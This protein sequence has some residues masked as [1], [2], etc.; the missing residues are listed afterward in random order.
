MRSVSRLF[1]VVAGLLLLLLLAGISGWLPRH[2]WAPIVLNRVLPGIE[3]TELRGLTVS[4][5]T[6]SLSAEIEHLHLL[7]DS[8]LGVTIEGARLTDLPALLRRALSGKPRT[9]VTSQLHI[10]SVSLQSL[11]TAETCAPSPTSSS[12]P[13]AR[14]PEHP[15]PTVTNGPQPSQILISDTLH[16]LRN[17]PISKVTVDAFNWPQRIDGHLSLTALNAPGHQISAQI[18]SSQCTSC[19]LDLEILTPDEGSTSI[20][21]RLSHHDKRVAEFQGTLESKDT[22][23]RGRGAADWRLDSQLNILAQRLAPLMEQ[24]EVSPASSQADATDW[25]AIARSL[26]G[27]IQLTLLGEVPD[28]LHSMADVSNF[29][30]T[31]HAPALSLNIPE[32]LAGLPLTVTYASEA[33]L[34]LDVP[35]ISPLIVNSVQGEFRVTVIPASDSNASTNGVSAPSLLDAK[36]ALTTEQSAPE[37][38]FDGFVNLAQLAPMT[39]SEKWQSILGD[40]RL[41]ELNGR[42]SF[43]GRAGL[44]TFDTSTSSSTPPGLRDLSVQVKT[45]EPVGFLLSLPE[46]T[47][48]LAAT[49]WQKLLV[50]ATLEQPLMITAEKIPGSVALQIPR[51]EFDSAMLQKSQHGPSSNTPKLTGKLL[52]LQC[53]A[54]PDIACALS[55]DTLLTALDLADSK[56]ALKAVKLETK[57]TINR[58]SDSQDLD[59]SFTNLNLVADK[60]ASGPLTILT[61]EFFTQQASCQFQGP[62]FSCNAPQLAISIAPLSLE[63]NRIEGAVFLKDLAIQGDPNAQHGLSARAQFHSEGLNAE[64]LKQF[65]TSFAT[66]GQLEMKDGLISG[67]SALSSGPIKVTS[68]WQHNMNTGKGQ[69]DLKLPETNFSPGNALS[70]AVQGLPADIV[71]GHLSASARLHWPEKG[72]D[73]LSL[74]MRNTGLQYNESFAVGVNTALQLQQSGGHWISQKPA[75]VSIDKV[76]TGVAIN[77]LHFTLALQAD[78][79]ITLKDFAAELLE[80]V[81]TSQQLTWNQDGK[82]RRSLVKFTGIS[83]GA[84]ARE[85][86]STNF[87]A[88]GLLDATLPLTTDRQGVTIAEGNLQ[89]RPPGGRLRYYGAFSQAMLGNNPQLKLI[90]GALEDYNYRD[91]QGTV[92]YPLNGDLLLNMKLTGRSAAIDA[93]RDLIINLN[94]ENNVPTM[95]RS[96]RASRDL[97]DVLEQQVQ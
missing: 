23:T 50:T 9:A 67:T 70:N 88:S 96:L 5:A 16:R 15:A 92:N 84:L 58:P 42:S 59:A 55:L 27:D 91:I 85:M 40:Y 63:E 51:L 3:V 6:G 12:S 97:T 72:Q 86:E 13:T 28:K 61:P 94:L 60:L 39:S 46:K 93:N 8:R 21:I 69:L 18:L 73:R 17:I 77:N 74:T 43:T 78:G 79:D 76:D 19:V 37:A 53:N 62:G 31:L 56:T 10:K 11:A 68:N 44:P 71:D 47:N 57:A 22:L 24:L 52:D 29:S 20:Q 30:A 36:V 87:A 1:T 41:A 2:H 34:A 48:P 14:V 81:L 66:D 83:I 33:P 90:A 54:L 26:K 4:R 89:S 82:E 45:E 35:S 80:G 49:G 25:I 65:K 7:T 75:R 95:L 38:L 32:E 64:A